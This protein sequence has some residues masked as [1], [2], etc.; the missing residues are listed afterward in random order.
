MGWNA[1]IVLHLFCA[2]AAMAGVH[3]QGN[4]TKEDLILNQAYEGARFFFL[5]DFARQFSSHWR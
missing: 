2:M 3:S 4:S 5:I 1:L